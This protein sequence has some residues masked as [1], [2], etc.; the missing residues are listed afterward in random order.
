MFS[1]WTT[2]DTQALLL[3]L[4]VAVCCVGLLLIPGI[5]L[6]WLLARKN[7]MG[8]NV[9]EAL[10]HLPLVLPPVVVGYGLLVMT[11]RTSWLGHFL[12]S[13]FGIRIA[14]TWFAAVLASSLMALPLMVRAVKQAIQAVDRGQEQA[15][16]VCGASPG[17]VWWTITL[18]AAMPGVIS[19]IILAFARSV[20]EF[21]ATITFAGNIEG[22]TRTLPL[23]IFRAMQIPNAEDSVNRLVIASIILSLS[24][25]FFSEWLS[26]RYHNVAQT[27]L[28][29]AKAHA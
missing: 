16:S 6:G 3:T 2:S 14:F 28:S 8:R 22:Q 18:P 10:V 15:A 1:Q 11:G 27:S 29:R 4:R 9:L 13:T 20:G 24:A 12:E 21:G 7:F 23:A 5:G 17:R 26:R 25:V 19:G